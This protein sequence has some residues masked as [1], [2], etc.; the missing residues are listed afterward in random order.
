MDGHTIGQLA[1]AASVPSSTIR[2]Y[3]RRGL[4]QAPARTGGNY[5]LYTAG[6]LER[7]RFIRSAQAT[8]FSLSDVA[9][10][11]SL[12]YSDEP[13]CKEVVSLAEARLADVRKRLKELRHV[14]KTLTRALQGCCTGDGMDLCQEVT[15][16]SPKKVAARA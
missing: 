12:A 8:G 10:L 3:E 7:L 13:P 9:E 1:R 4:L 6:S 11:L 16:L 5:R 15:R 14:E 2:Y